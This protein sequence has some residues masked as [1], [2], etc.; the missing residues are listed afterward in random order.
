MRK[1]FWSKSLLLGLMLSIGQ[2]VFA[3]DLK[4]D[5]GY[6]AQLAAVESQLKK[7]DIGGA[8]AII[9]ET[10]QQ[11]PNGSDLYYAKSLLYAQVRNFDVAIPAAEQAVE[12]SPDNMLYKNHLLELY[13]ASE[14]YEDAIVFLD[15]LIAD[16]KDNPQLYREKIMLM[17]SAK[18]SLEALKVYDETKA[19]FGVSDTL[20]VLKAEI[21]MDLDRPRE[22]AEALKPWREKK[23][24]IRQ[25][26]SS[27]SYIYVDASNF[28]DALTVLEEGLQN[29]KDDLLYLDLADAYLA[30]KKS[31]PAY[32][33]LKKAFGSETVNYFD[34][35]R[36]MFKVMNEPADFSIDQKQELANLLVLK[37]PR[38]ADSHMFKGDVLWQKG[39][40][41]QARSLYLTAVAMQPQLI[42]AWRKLVNI[43]LAMNKVSLAITDGMEGLQRHPGNVMLSYFIGVAHMMNKDH[44]EARK[45]LEA[46]LDR[47][48]DEDPLV[49]SMVY[50]SLGDL[51]NE[52]K[53]YAESDVAYEEAIKLDSANSNAMNNY[54]Y[55][56]SLRK[57]KLDKAAKYAEQANK[58]EKNSGTFQ[59]TYAWVLF[60]QAK[61][62][63]ALYWIEL[64]LK[65][66]E[67]SA[68]LLDHYGD[69]LIQLGRSK[70]AVKQWERALSMTNKG[71]VDVD[72]LKKKISEKKYID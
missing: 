45:F 72:K 27:L 69:I 11:Y 50:S 6:K 34:K 38:I 4:N 62:K 36:A 15:K 23:T 21:L 64:A 56:L 42:D 13:K 8:L 30:Q 22:A 16:Q 24:K 43:D 48:A 47:S 33:S 12:K 28:K 25:V 29:S 3:Q 32:E 5:N 54:A 65:N 35:H 37:Y 63:E 26:Y 9:E 66:S 1:N 51:Y 46:A 70:E 39:E 41:D 55:Y 31:K 71:S 14:D 7:G 59:D 57:E 44:A 40:M 60:Q 10:L 2:V 68:T 18:L 20:D 53:L 52:L 67:T 58:L 17:H 61:Y 19:K 49:Q